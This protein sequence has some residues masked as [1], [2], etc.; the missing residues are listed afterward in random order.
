MLHEILR[1]RKSPGFEI[2]FVVLKMLASMY[3]ERKVELKV[4]FCFRLPRPKKVCSPGWGSSDALKLF[5]IKI[6]LCH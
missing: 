5:M 2:L 6:C 1:P 3:L 4:T